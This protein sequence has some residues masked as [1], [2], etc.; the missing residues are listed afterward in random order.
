MPLPIPE[1]LQ[2]AATVIDTAKKFS[3]NDTNIYR[4]DL[5][6]ALERVNSSDLHAVLNEVGTFYAAAANP[7]IIGMGCAANLVDKTVDLAIKV[8]T[9]FGPRDTF[10]KMSPEQ[11]KDMIDKLQ[12][13]LDQLRPSGLILN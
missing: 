2:N 10:L 9:G 8:V 6:G 1:I 3:E 11:A 13:D 7:Q 12:K 4:A 5:K